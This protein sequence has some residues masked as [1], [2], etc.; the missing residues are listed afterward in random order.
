MGTRKR[1][2]SDRVLRPPM[3][4]PG[5]P[6]GWRREH[7]QRFWEAIARGLS[8]EEAGVAAGVSPAVGTRWFREG[9]GMRTVSP[10]LLSGRYLWFVERKAACAAVGRPRATHYRWHRKSPKPAR[11]DRVPKP[12]PRALDKVERKEVLRVLHEPEHVDEAPATVCAELLDAGI[13]L[14]STSTMY[15]ILGAEGEVS[16]RRRQASH[17]AADRPIAR[18]LSGTSSLRFNARISP[19]AGSRATR[20]PGVS[21]D[22]T[23][24]GWLS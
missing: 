4:S 15:R 14:A 17:N 20:D 6:A 11:P 10:A 24:T 12:Q 18:P 22:R 3:R 21:P 5:R 23:H 13:Y 7:Q 9:G 1:R 2:R 16:E 8:S 19:D